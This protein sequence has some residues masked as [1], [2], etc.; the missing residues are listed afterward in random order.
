MGSSSLS[1]RRESQRLAAVD[2]VR[3]L[4]MVLMTLDHSSS[5]FN[6]KRM[7]ADGAAMFR[8]D[9]VFEPAQ[10]VTRWVTHLC[11]PTFV[12]LAGLSLALSVARRQRAGAHGSSI[13]RT[14][15]GPLP[16]GGAGRAPPP[17]L[18]SLVDR[19]T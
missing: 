19:V 16:A 13:D 14:G 4:V 10:F 5:A 8:L 11:A 7:M 17:R 1:D 9:Q 2:I 15:A 18:A 3:G 12:F 6:G